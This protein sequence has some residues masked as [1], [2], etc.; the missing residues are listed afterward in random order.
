[1]STFRDAIAQAIND[2]VWAELEPTPEN[3]TEADAVLAMPEM[4]AIRKALAFGGEALTD[5][6]KSP[7]VGL[8]SIDV[9]EHIIA[10]VLDGDT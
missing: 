4:Q 2:T 1:M 7:D 9:P 6:M 10:W 5:Y 8:R 3:L